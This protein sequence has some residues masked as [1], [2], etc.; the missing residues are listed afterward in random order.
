MGE[1]MRYVRDT[2]GITVDA[3]SRKIEETKLKNMDVQNVS[4]DGK[5]KNGAVKISFRIISLA[6]KKPLLVAF[7]GSPAVEKKHRSDL[8]RMLQS[9]EKA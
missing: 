6:E 2:S 4:W 7:W 9:I 1:V 8:D 3:A 5:D